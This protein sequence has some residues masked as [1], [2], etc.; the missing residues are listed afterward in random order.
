MAFVK[1]F[2]AAFVSFLVL[3]FI[4]LGFVMKKFNM[5][6]TLL[7]TL[8]FL[9]LQAGAQTFVSVEGDMTWQ[10][11]NDQRVPGDTGTL[12]SVADF[13]E[14]PFP[15]Y[16][17]YIGHIWNNRHEIRALYA[18][19][20]IEV[21][22]QFAEAV[23]YMDSTFAA[24]TDT[25]AHYKFNSYRLTYA[26]HFESS[27]DWELALGFTGK[28]RDAEVRL[29]QGG[30]TESKSNV[31]FVPLLNLQAVRRLGSDW[32]FRFDMDGMAAPQG[33]AIDAALL[34]ERSISTSGLSLFG[35]YRTIEGGAD[36]DEVY[37]FAWIHK[38]VLGLR[39]EF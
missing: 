12:F 28:V 27:G 5:K 25:T 2:G 10:T 4:W 23:S 8:L 16:R 39:G 17:I 26:Y 24:N 13:D 15:T 9:S 33:R 32:R 34:L 20:E 7:S 19:L 29:T 11:L 6:A 35:G 38:A 21:D 3:D 1:Q 36:N 22:G 37:N 18:P 31:G 30:L 14:G